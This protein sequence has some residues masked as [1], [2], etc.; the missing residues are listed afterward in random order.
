MRAD[1]TDAPAG[2]EYATVYVAFELSKAKWQLGLMLPGTEKMSR[3]L[4]D[5][6]NL[7]QLSSILARARAKAE[8]LGKPVRILSCYEAGLDGH[9]LHRWLRTNGILN[10]EIDASSIEV[11]RRARRA[12]TDRIDLAQLMRSFLAY[13]RGEPRVCSVVRVPTPEDEDRKRRTRERER[14]LNERTAHSNRI[15]GLLHGQGIRDAMPLKPRFLSDLDQM[16]TGDGR[17][18]PPHLKD[19]IRREHERLVLV[20]KQIAALEA[21]NIA[22]HRAPAK[23]S[24]EAKVVQLAQLKAIGPQIAQVLT[25]EVFY[26]D[27]KNR[28]QVGSC[29]GLTDTPYDSGASRRQQGISKAGNH[30]ARTTAIELG[31]LWLR[32]QPDSELSRWF[33]ERVGNVKG[34]IRKI[35]IVALARKLMVALWRYLE[36]GLVPTGAVMR[37]SF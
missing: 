22:A 33:R 23:G 14:L 21:E 20:H 24:V 1:H 28:R 9:W 29:F 37:P 3:Y 31:W 11:N 10:Y 4:I 32:H 15:K 6:G 18:L 7:V 34:R 13:Q 5:G 36:T 26:R 17:V 27:F 19:E 16:R 2:C 25:N 8:Q 12:K 35:A 30:R